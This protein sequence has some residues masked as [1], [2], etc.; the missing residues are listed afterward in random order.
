MTLHAHLEH[1]AYFT[2]YLVCG[3]PYDQVIQETRADDLHKTAEPGES[4]RETQAKLNAFLNGLKSG[5]FTFFP[6]GCRMLPTETA[7]HTQLTLTVPARARKPIRC[8]CSEAKTL[9][10]IQFD[11]IT[12][13]LYKIQ[14]TYVY[15]PTHINIYCKRLMITIHTINKCASICHKIKPNKSLQYPIDSQ[16]CTQSWLVKIKISAEILSN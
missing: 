13:V 16:Y 12:S 10:K 7:G 3:K 5:V 4:V 6:G 14:H 1:N 8:P 9:I 11:K 2:G 15:K